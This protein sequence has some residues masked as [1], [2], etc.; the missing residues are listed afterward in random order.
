MNITELPRLAGPQKLQYI[1]KYVN[2][3]CKLSSY[4]RYGTYY[5]NL[6]VVG[7]Y[8]H[9]KLTVAVTAH[10]DVVNLSSDNCLDNTASVYNL[11]MLSHEIN[12]KSLEYNIILGF[13]D[14]E[15]SCDIHKNGVSDLIDAYNPDYLIDLE[16]SSSGNQL[17]STRYGDF[18]IGQFNDIRQPYNNALAA[19]RYASSSKSK[20]RGSMCVSLASDEDLDELCEGGYCY[21]WSMCHSVEDTFDKWLNYDDMKAFR[22]C[23]I[24]LIDSGS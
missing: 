10:H 15:E 17:I 11:A 18:S 16:L 23:I 13:T 4:Y 22:E 6:Y 14:A 19:H 9:K 12:S 2:G 7:A 3:H 8:D 1:Q 24:K 20:L 5:H 21:R